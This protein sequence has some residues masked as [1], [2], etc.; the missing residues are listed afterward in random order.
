MS[1]DEPSQTATVTDR[2]GHVRLAE[3]VR[4]SAPW[5][6]AASLRLRDGEITALAEYD[7]RA[8]I[9]GGDPEQMLDAAAFAYWELVTRQQRQ[10]AVTADA[11]LRRRY[12]GQPWP[13]LRSAEPE[14][15]PEPESQ[16]RHDRPD[17]TVEAGNQ[18]TGLHIQDLAARHREFSE[19][20]AER[21]SLMIPAENPD[22]EDLGPAFPVREGPARDAILQP[23]KPQIQPSQQIMERMASREADMEAGN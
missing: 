1:H 2:L 5:E 23:P 21:Q 12:P 3:P 16:A 18:Q 13:P 14:P 9:T 19:R 7:Q 8:R 11:E 22:F 6:Q 17:F 20:L 4:F 15:E 10:L